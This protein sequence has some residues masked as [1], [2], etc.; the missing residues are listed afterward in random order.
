MSV[1]STKPSTGSVAM[2]WRA[3]RHGQAEVG[4]QRGDAGNVREGVI[5]DVGGPGGGAAVSERAGAGRAVAAAELKP[6]QSG[7]LAGTGHGG[8]VWVGLGQ[9]GQLSEAS[10]TPSPSLSIPGVADG[11]GDGVRV[12]VAVGDGEAVGVAVGVGAAVAVALAVG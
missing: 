10:G 5:V 11:V 1:M 9:L 8:S 4:R 2:S 12:G 7:S 3:G 6:S